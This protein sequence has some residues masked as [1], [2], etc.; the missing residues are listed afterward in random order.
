L[1]PVVTAFPPEEPAELKVPPDS[2]ERL[3]SA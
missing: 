1:I 2:F 3:V